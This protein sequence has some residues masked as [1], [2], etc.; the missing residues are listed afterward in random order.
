ML[1]APSRKAELD[2]TQLN[3]IVAS[4][5]LSLVHCA[6]EI[7]H[8]LGCPEEGLLRAMDRGVA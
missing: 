7:A 3:L 4:A 5:Q 6:V 8:G 1:S 2:S